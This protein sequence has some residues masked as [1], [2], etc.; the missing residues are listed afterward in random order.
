[1]DHD[2]RYKYDP[3]TCSFVEVETTWRQRLKKVGRIV[4]LAVVLAGL[5]LWMIDAQ[6][7]VTPDEQMLR[8]ENRALEKQLRRASTQLSS[9][10]D[11]VD[12]LAKKDRS[13]YRKLLQIE[14]ISKGVRQVGV[15][16]S[17][18]HQKFERFDEATADLL[19]KTAS[20]LDELERRVSLQGKSYRELT[21]IAKNREQRLTQLPAIRP[22]NG[23]LVSGYGMRHHPILDVRKMHAGV[24]FLLRVGTPVMATADGVV[25]RARYNS[26]YGNYVDI[27][28][29]AAGY[30]TRYAHLSEIPDSIG[31]GVRVERGDTIALSGNTGRSTGPHLHYEVRKTNGRTLDPMKFFVPDMTPRTYHKLEKRTQQYEARMTG[32][33]L[34][35]D[36]GGAVAA[37]SSSAGSSSGSA[38]ADASA[39]SGEPDGTATS[40]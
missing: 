5:A 36:E 20:T 28:H 11:K 40:S 7:M 3:E 37:G 38:S 12:H 23:R 1:M 29:E 32:K 8:S 27:E 14:P 35:M 16:G 24:D 2:T 39:A 33:E 6:W 25:R 17:E 10:S 31:R 21:R 26:S 15:G 13:L 9:L 19:K 30:V 18:P 34:P 22:A 4:G